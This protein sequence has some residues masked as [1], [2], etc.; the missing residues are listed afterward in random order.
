MVFFFSFSIQGF[1]CIW[2][3][4]HGYPSSC[5]GKFQLFLLTFFR[6]ESGWHDLGSPYKIVICV[7][8]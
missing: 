3:G 7:R 4:I 8:I 5:C 2:L 6:E 1:T